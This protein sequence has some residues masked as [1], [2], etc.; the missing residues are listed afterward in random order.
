MKLENFRMPGEPEPYSP[1]EREQARRDKLK[2]ELFGEGVLK[3]IGNIRAGT[4][5]I[6]SKREGAIDM[7]NM[8]G[9]VD[10]EVIQRQ[11]PMAIRNLVDRGDFTVQEIQRELLQILGSELFGLPEDTEGLI[12]HSGSE[13]NEV[14]LYLAKQTTNKRLVLASNLTHQ[15]I[16]RA[17]EK[18]GLD[19][20]TLNGD[21]DFLYEIP[22]AELEK[23]LNQRGN[24]LAAIVATA[25]TTQLGTSEQFI[26]HPAVERLCREQ[27]TWLHIDAAY[28]GTISNLISDEQPSDISP[29]LARSI[30]VDAHK[31]IGVLGC[32][33]L[34]LPRKGD[35]Q[36]IGPEAPY[37]PSHASA[38]GTTRSA[39]E[40]AVALATMKALGREG[41]KRLA[42]ISHKRATKV[43]N[44]LEKA[45]LKMM[46]PIQSG[47]V[48]IEL[49]SEKAVKFM[50]TSLEQNGFLVS[51]VHINGADYDKWGIRIVVTPK[52]EMTDENLSSFTAKV[53]ELYQGM[54]E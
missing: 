46:A 16:T 34:L 12:L 29:W 9:F 50:R 28:G 14:A 6:A 39:F 42:H 41:L 21:P 31:F 49:P 26:N 18:L 7:Y 8:S 23:A 13:A 27:G 2:K 1:P 48:P 51:P 24:E 17:C 47:V 15:S 52:A 10:A 44:E 40:P 54:P 45:G 20:L 53:A 5:G 25:G 32:S 22:N 35:T 33:A 30:T 38:L 37:F 43:A 36:L 11:I 4:S 3:N 19:I